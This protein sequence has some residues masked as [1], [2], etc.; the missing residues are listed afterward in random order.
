MWDCGC[1]CGCGDGT[2]VVFY[3]NMTNF[4]N[5][6]Q[7]ATK[8]TGE[9]VIT[10][11]GANTN[12]GLSYT[13][14]AGN[15]EQQ[16][17]QTFECVTPTPAKFVD[18]I[19]EPQGVKKLYV[20]ASVSFT[21]STGTTT[22]YVTSTKTST[23]INPS[24]YANLYGYTFSDTDLSGSGAPYILYYIPPVELQTLLKNSLNTSYSFGY[25][26]INPL[27]LAAIIAQAYPN[28]GVYTKITSAETGALVSYT[29]D[30]IQENI[31]NSAVLSTMLSDINTQNSRIVSLVVPTQNYSVYPYQPIITNL[32]YL[33]SFA[34]IVVPIVQNGQQVNSQLNVPWY[35]EVQLIVKAS[36]LGVYVPVAEPKIMGYSPQP[37]SVRSGTSSI[38]YITVENTGSTSGNMYV[39][40]SCGQESF[41][42][43]SDAQPSD[44]QQQKLFTLSVNGG[45]NSQN[46]NQ[47]VS[48]TATAYSSTDSAYSSSINFNE[49][50]V[51]V[52]TN[53]TQQFNGNTC[54]PFT[55]IPTT[56]VMPETCQQLNNC[57][58]SP[59]PWYAGL[60]IYI[61]AGIVIIVVA[62]LLTR[63]GD[64]GG[65]YIN[66]YH[67]RR[68]SRPA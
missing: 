43:P 53:E 66:P 8:D 67:P 1:R 18:V 15:N 62:Y 40:G 33:P 49:N 22:G 57:P 20:N 24:L 2:A 27:N 46:T 45:T 65:G 29:V 52:C 58:S 37:F 26:A 14:L 68:Y 60:G 34:G 54:Q 23:Q 11:N 3:E 61:V 38:L 6:C 17:S 32:P 56:T 30:G 64:F 28:T 9:L 19:Y 25:R 13:L 4:S 39:V 41:G 35:P 50:L 10:Q 47:T 7:H 42:S 5:A 59:P 36:S 63:K 51:P 48:C 21:N 31:P 16:I 44:A 12:G 55:T